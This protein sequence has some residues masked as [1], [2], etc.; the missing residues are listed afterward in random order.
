MPGIFVP[1]I[2]AGFG[3]NAGFWLEPD[4]G[5]A[6]FSIHTAQ[7]TASIAILTVLNLPS[8]AQALEAMLS[9]FSKF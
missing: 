8:V 5:S 7:Y 1:N 9:F 4:S 2:F 3:K 6:L